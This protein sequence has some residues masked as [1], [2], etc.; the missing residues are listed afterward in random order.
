MLTM[1]QAVQ[2][3]AQTKK[4]SSSTTTTK[5]SSK[6]NKTQKGAIIGAGTGAVVGGVI[7][8]KSK[9]TAIG[10]IIGATV[11]GATGAVIGNKMDKKAKEMEEAL[12]KKAEVERIGEGVK[13]TLG[14]KL[15]FDF[16]SST[17][18]QENYEVLKDFAQ[19]LKKDQDETQL[20]IEGNTDSIGS[21]EF[22]SKLSRER[23]ASVYD[24]LVKEGVVETRLKIVGNGENHPVAPNDTELGRQ[25]NR[26]VE[27]GIF[28]SET[29]KKSAEVVA[30]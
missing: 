30:N 27:I 12:G 9:N 15:L 29:M 11:G 20:L 17:L 14:D 22:N 8:A 28:A 16:G 23:A 21:A 4:L 1:G 3:E 26:R 6:L 19:T 18:K 5:K 7:G 24:F 25:K 2:L 10:A 13:V